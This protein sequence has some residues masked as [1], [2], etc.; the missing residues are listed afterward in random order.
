MMSGAKP[1]IYLAGPFSQ[2]DPL[3]NIRAAC[4]LAGGLRDSGLVTPLVPHL[5]GLWHLVAPRPYADWLA[6]DLELLARCDAL[7]RFGGASPGAEAEVD[8]AIRAG[9]PAFRTRSYLM[10]WVK[11]WA[12]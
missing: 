6:Y 10:Q 4:L 9:I 5:G 8:V 11:G 12:K 2:P 1:L 3:V 7:L